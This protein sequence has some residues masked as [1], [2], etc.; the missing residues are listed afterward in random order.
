MNPVN[1][2]IQLQNAPRE[3]PLIASVDYP[4]GWQNSYFHNIP[5]IGVLFSI[6]GNAPKYATN[7]EDC[8]D[9]IAADLARIE[10]DFVG[11]RVG[12]YDTGKGKGKIE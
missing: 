6:L 8:A 4:P 9:F 7:L 12:V 10:S 11:H 1:K 2:T 5:V 3:N